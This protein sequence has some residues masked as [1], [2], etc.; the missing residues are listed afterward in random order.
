VKGHS[1]GHGIDWQNDVCA[2][3]YMMKISDTAGAG[4]ANNALCSLTAG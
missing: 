4:Y 3:S 1:P 2:V